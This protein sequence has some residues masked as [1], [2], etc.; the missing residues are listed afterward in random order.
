[1]RAVAAAFAVLAVTASRSGCGDGASGYDPC[2]MKA[3]GDACTLCAPGDAGCVEGAEQK[4]CD[5]RGQCVPATT[6][7]TCEVAD[8]CAGK[9]CGQ[10]CVVALPCESQTPPCLAPVAAGTCDYGGNC[11]PGGA[12]SCMP[13]DS[14][15]GQACGVPCTDMMMMGCSTMMGSPCACDGMGTCVSAAM[16]ACPMPA[17]DPCAGK[18]C[19]DA[20][21][22]CGGMCGHPYAMACDRSGQC[23]VATPG[24][25]PGPP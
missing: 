25:C 17:A 20:C 16:L 22:P 10:S 4:V 18:A 15:M 12:A 13:V 19:G 14:C 21:D 24:T 23:V 8:A 3:C 11:V 5:P 9:A 6:S 2:G 1:M 7:F